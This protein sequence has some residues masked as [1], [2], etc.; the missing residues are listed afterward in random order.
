[1]YFYDLCWSN[2]INFGAIVYRYRFNEHV[3]RDKTI[4]HVIQCL[5]NKPRMFTWRNNIYIYIYTL[6][7]E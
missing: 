4:T 2:L 3:N 5:S 1:M 6:D 7:I